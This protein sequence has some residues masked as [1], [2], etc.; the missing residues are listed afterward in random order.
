MDDMVPQMESPGPGPSMGGPSPS[1]QPFTTRFQVPIAQ[2]PANQPALAQ[3]VTQQQPREQSVTHSMSPGSHPLRPPVANFGYA[4]RD[5]APMPQSQHQPHLQHQPATQPSPHQS[6]RISQKPG[7][8]PMPVGVSSPGP[9]SGLVS[10]PPVTDVMP[11]RATWA[12]EV[13]PHLSQQAQMTQFPAQ[14]REA[15]ERPARVLESQLREGPRHA[16]RAPVRLKQESEHIPHYETSFANSQHPHRVVASRPEPAQQQMLRQQH[17]DQTRTVTSAPPQQPLFAASSSSSQPQAARNLHS[18][19]VMNLQSHQHIQLGERGMPLGIKP[20]MPLTPTVQMQDPYSAAATPVPQ[21]PPASAP[22]APPRAPEPR[23]SNLFALLNDDAPAPPKRVADVS[24]GLKPSST[25]PPQSMSA[26]PPPPS[27]ASTPLRREAEPPAYAASYRNPGAPTSVM[28]SL[29]PYNTQSPQPHHSSIHRSAM[30]SP[31]DGAPGGPERGDYYSRHA[32]AQQQ[33][34]QQAANSPQGLQYL[35]QPQH[36]QQQSPMPYQ[37]QSGYPPYGPSVSQQPHSTSPAPPFSAHQTPGVRREPG[38]E[39]P[40]PQWAQ[41]GQQALAPAQRQPDRGMQHQSTAWPSN[42]PAPKA[43]PTPSAWGSEHGPG[44]SNK[45]QQPTVWNQAP[46]AQQQ[47]HTS[48]GL[49]DDL[50]G[51][52]AYGGHDQRPQPGM[53]QHGHHL[54]LS[55]RYPAQQDARRQ[56]QA[57]PPPQAQHGYG[58]YATSQPPQPQRDH[59]PPQRSYTPTNAYDPRGPPPPSGP[60]VSGRPSHLQMQEMQQMREMQQRDMMEQQQQ[61]QQQQREMQQQQQQLQGRMQPNNLR[62]P[63]AGTDGFR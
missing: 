41:P 39:Q 59:G 18:D 40:Q 14:P 21:A 10:Q 49:R 62:P 1:A 29:K 30:V 9:G 55:G 7:P 24:S 34:H 63:G 3:P 37:S 53:V 56:E 32:Y 38:R 19:S 28:P 61:Q 52:P 25:P 36:A 42:Q 43:N 51:Q 20:A 16:E 22:L 15:R 45:P 35:N 44:A 54:S 48:L 11:P 50:R 6:G 31:A 57:G 46:Q 17:A 47:Q 2:A 60:P 4:E 5:E 33:Q 12:A 23:K 13:N 58:R 27:A 8:V 26:R